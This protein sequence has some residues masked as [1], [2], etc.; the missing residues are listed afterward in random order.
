MLK[1]K[2]NSGCEIEVLGSGASTFVRKRSAGSN[3]DKRL[4][5]QAQ[6]Q[7]AYLEKVSVEC[8]VPK[9]I[10]VGKDYFDMELFHGMDVVS[11]VEVCSKNEVDYL[12]SKLVE[13]IHATI[14]SCKLSVFDKERFLN[15]FYSIKCDISF[16][17]ADVEV[18]ENFFKSL[19]EDKI[20]FG[21]CH[22]DLT[23]SNVLV[24]KTDKKVCLIDF[25]D[26]FYETPLQDIVK[27]RQDTRYMWTYL[28]YNQKYDSVRHK[29]VMS[30]L[31]KKIVDSF[32]EY[33]FYQTYYRPFQMMNFLRIA[34]Y[35]KDEK[36]K[37]FVKNKLIEMIS[38]WT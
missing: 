18:V 5:N 30:Y 3:Y 21:I 38:K 8:T 10:E 28:L 35:A 33:D 34:P 4:I 32:S 12:F 20:P 6:K 9:I 23:L 29:S 17:G 15:K 31:D 16:L 7:D 13:I 11:Y 22:G 19:P 1:I 27:L 25:L 37:R 36:K 26:T 24:S 14:E 2:G